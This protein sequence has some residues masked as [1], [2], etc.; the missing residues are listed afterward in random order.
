MPLGR[1]STDY[2]LYVFHGRVAAVQVHLDREH[3]HRW[4]LFDPAWRRLSSASANPDPPPP[5]SLAQMIIG[6]ERLAHGFDFVRVDFYDI[7]SIPRFGEMT[8]YPGS[9]LD[10][11]D[12][13]DLD[14]WL[15]K[16]WLAD[17]AL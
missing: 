15:G 9:G 17:A 16:L 11:F 10:R 12:P 8:F 4:M 14:A 3:G 7:G 5:G 13:P 6:A 1:L 2:K